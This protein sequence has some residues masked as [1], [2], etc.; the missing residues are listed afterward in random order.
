MVIAYRAAVY[1]HEKQWHTDQNNTVAL[2][3]CL[4]FSSALPLMQCVLHLCKHFPLGS[5]IWPLLH[6]DAMR[7]LFAGARSDCAIAL[8]N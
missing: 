3:L 8:S 2:Q 1:Y 4:V 7:Q 6:L 5:R